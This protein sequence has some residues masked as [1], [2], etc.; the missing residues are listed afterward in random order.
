MTKSGMPK[1]KGRIE[2]TAAAVAIE[3]GATSGRR[4]LSMGNIL[5]ILGP[6]PS[7]YPVLRSYT[8]HPE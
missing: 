7:F 3:I 6:I 5:P 8:I 4:M 2:E 1:C